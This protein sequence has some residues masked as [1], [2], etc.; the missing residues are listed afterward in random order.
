MEKLT[1][2]LLIAEGVASGTKILEKTILLARRFGARVELLL[3]DPREM[4]VFAALCAARSFEEV[5]LCSVHRGPEPLNDLILRRVFERSPDLVVKAPLGEH[6]AGAGAFAREDQQLAVAC[7]VPLILM[8]EHAWSSPVRIAAA[9]D[10]SSDDTALAR[11]IVHVS[12]FLNL[13][14][15][16]ELDVFYSEREQEDEV[17]RMARAVKLARLVREFHVAGEHL[18]HVDGAPEKTLPPIAASGDYDILIL[19]AFTHH[20]GLSALHANLTRRLVSAFDGDIVLVKKTL[21]ST[22][23]QRAA[24]LRSLATS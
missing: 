17:L 22:A 18:R 3:G 2:I 12:G 1:S 5:V 11:S 7:P 19:G 8:R 9:V 24:P 20:E 4:K 13:G 6:A 23:E 21:P 14:F 10:V 15:E 16:G